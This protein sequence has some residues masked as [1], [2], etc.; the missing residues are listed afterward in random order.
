MQ[1]T[2]QSRDAAC[3]INPY[4][5]RA[6]SRSLWR[7]RQDPIRSDLLQFARD[8][9]LMLRDAV[10]LLDVGSILVAGVLVAAT[11]V[12]GPEII[13]RSVLFWLLL[14]SGL[15]ATL[16]FWQESARSAANAQRLLRFPL[17]RT[18]T[19]FLLLAISAQAA[20]ELRPAVLHYLLAW[21]FLGTLLFGAARLAV[22][23]F[24]RLVLPGDAF[25]ERFAI[26][27]AGP[28]ADRLVETL[29]TRAR[30]A[31]KVL[32]IF[33]DRT[34]MRGTMIHGAVGTLSDLLKLGRRTTIDHI[35]IALPIAA[36]T[37]IN[38]LA[39]RLKA[40]ATDIRVYP[41]Y[42][43]EFAAKSGPGLLEGVSGVPFF[44]LALRPI[45]RWNSVLKRLEDIILASL[46][47]IIVGPV[48][49]AAAIAIKLDSPGP[50]L[51][52]QRRHGYNNS[53][54]EILKF[55]S[56]SV[57]QA[58]P[59]G[60]TQTK[61][62]DSRITRVGGF[63]RRT[64]IDELPQLIN[65]LRGDMSMVGPRPLPVGMRTANR[66]CEEIVEDFAHRHRVKPGITGW[67]QVNGLRG[68][69]ATD[70]Q[71]RARID[72]DLYYIEN[73]SVL[74]DARILVQTAFALASSENAF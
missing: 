16:L 9:R 19:V 39:R 38:E 2:Q 29:E 23:G 10:R 58:D 69:T 14:T 51:F 41:N 27:G 60:A 40:L 50:V 70:S 5:V 6:P 46:C 17:L 48:M 68:A 52:R 62:N 56:M 47:L 8:V 1:N 21:S 7:W 55:R 59:L 45:A 74:F 34:V 4:P 30:G 67:A 36:E 12:G 32:G 35:V 61:R 13:P 73:W 31:V 43:H 11:K 64:S 54:I 53:E 28:I 22:Y 20:G 44:T 24:A 42:T 3:D 25:V 57:D 33:D 72:Y 66:L 15:F 71:L 49:L 65:V 18:T 37:R 63:L 26:V